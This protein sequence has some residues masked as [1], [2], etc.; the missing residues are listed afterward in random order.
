MNIKRRFIAGAKCPKCEAMDRIVM[1]TQGDVE[2]I[3]CIECG[4]SENRPTHVDAP[5]EPAI[6]D[7]I[8]SYKMYVEERNN[9]KLMW[10]IAGGLI[11]VIL[12][13]AG[14]FWLNHS[15]ETAQNNE[16]IHQ[17][18]P[19]QKAP[20][21]AAPVTAQPVE[22]SAS[23]ANVE[24]VN[25]TILKDKVPENASLAKEEVAKLQDIQKQLD[26]QQQNLTSQHADADQL[27]K[28]KEEQIKILDVLAQTRSD[29]YPFFSVPV[30]LNLS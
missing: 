4:Y 12:L 10:I 19:A 25:E 9:S 11:A 28:L 14:F 17:T 15:S 21:V 24:L 30:R 7:E 20:Q 29:S 2:W 5:E 13:I 18:T 3:E 22:Q 8:G 16:Q 1:L 27:I 6:P 26:D 23:A